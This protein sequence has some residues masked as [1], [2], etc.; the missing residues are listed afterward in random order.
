MFSDCCHTKKHVNQ[1]VLI[2][3]L[4]KNWLSQLVSPSWEILSQKQ[5]E[6]IQRWS[7]ICHVSPWTL[8]YQKFLLCISSQGQVLYSHQKLDMYIYWF[9][10][11]SG[12]SCRQRQHWTQQY[13]HWGDISPMT[14]STAFIDWLCNPSQEVDQRKLGERLWL[15][16]GSPGLSWTK[17]IER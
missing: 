8:T 11:E 13:N 2:P 7:A 16:S 3:T 5:P 15:C 10:S 12:Y 6:A 1:S 14:C 4:N 9:S 17:S